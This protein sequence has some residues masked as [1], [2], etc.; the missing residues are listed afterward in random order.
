MCNVALSSRKSLFLNSSYSSDCVDFFSILYSFVYPDLIC[1]QSTYNSSAAF[2]FVMDYPEKHPSLSCLAAVAGYTKGEKYVQRI[3]TDID[4]YIHS[5]SLREKVS[6]QQRI[7]WSVHSKKGNELNRLF[8][9]KFLFLCKDQLKNI[10]KHKKKRKS[11][12][13]TI[14]LRMCM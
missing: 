1:V 5:P 10:K 4:T 12:H 2:L 6:N 14:Y 11:S 13:Y 8:P 9:S 7:Y 3:P